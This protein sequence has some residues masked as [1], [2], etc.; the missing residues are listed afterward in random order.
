MEGLILSPV[1]LTPMSD[2]QR[3][4]MGSKDP[5]TKAAQ[6]RRCPQS[7]PVRKASSQ[8]GPIS[9]PLGFLGLPIVPFNH[10]V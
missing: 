4:T 3:G 2:A 1:L 10:L 7:L 6:F 8:K 5:L 9:V